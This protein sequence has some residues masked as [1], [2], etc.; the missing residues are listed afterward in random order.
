M[1]VVAHPKPRST[2]ASATL[3]AFASTRRRPLSLHQHRQ[4]TVPPCL[5]QTRSSRIQTCSRRRCFGPAS[6]PLSALPSSSELGNRPGR[7]TPFDPTSTSFSAA[8]R[9]TGNTSLVSNWP[10]GPSGSPRL[11]LWVLLF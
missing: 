9:K 11:S 8:L 5:V 1:E 4:T 6:A 3:S 10:S 7:A 2:S